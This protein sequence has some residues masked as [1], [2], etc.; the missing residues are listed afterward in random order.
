MEM[1]TVWVRSS[2]GDKMCISKTYLYFG[3]TLSTILAAKPYLGAEINS[4][5][6]GSPLTII[7]P[8][9]DI[10]TPFPYNSYPSLLPRLGGPSNHHFACFTEFPTAA[11]PP[12]PLPHVLTGGGC[13]SLMSLS[14]IFTNQL[15]KVLKDTSRIL[16]KPATCEANNHARV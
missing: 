16:P 10:L 13:S 9:Q 1:C 3:A 15:D 12:T 7:T 5:S 14:Q 4:N 6:S 8:F 2:L 11:N